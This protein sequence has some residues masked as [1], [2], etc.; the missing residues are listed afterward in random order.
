GGANA[1]L[2]A[3]RVLADGTLDTSF[4]GDG[5]AHA[6]FGPGADEGEDLMIDANG[7][8]V[9]GGTA[10]GDTAMAVARF[11]TDG[12]LDTS[13]D[14]DGKVRIDFAGGTTYENAEAMTL[15]S[16]GKIVIAGRVGNDFAVARLHAETTGS[17]V[18]H[19]AV[20]DGNW[21]VTAVAASSDGTIVERFQYDPY[22][23]ATVL[24]A[25]FAADADGTS[26]IG[27]KHLHQG[28][29]FDGDTGLYHFNVGGNGRDYSSTLG[30]WLEQDR[31]PDGPY[32][33]GMNAYQY[34]G[35]SPVNYLDPEGLQRWY[36]GWGNLA[37]T[38]FGGYGSDAAGQVWTSAS[39]GAHD[40]ALAWANGVVPFGD[41]IPQNW[42]F[43]PCDEML[44]VSETMGQ[45]SREAWLAAAGMKLGKMSAGS[46]G[47]GKEFSH[48]IPNRHGGPRSVWNGNYVSPK[49]HAL[50]DPYRYR[51]MPKTW[52]ANNPMPNVLSQQWVRVPDALKGTA[53]GAMLGAADD[54][55]DDSDPCP[56]D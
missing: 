22:G 14:T 29:R 42:F 28:G 34:V 23:T 10:D 20:Q 31:H 56:C 3:A 45:V 37:Y 48:W 49:T 13:F 41:P 50:S 30:R 19:Y 35:S 36:Q 54:Y 47:K 32:V 9:V 11:N 17:D 7:K 2:V 53:G 15:Q 6:D 40:G 5:L 55:S 1:D 16:D 51:F 18:R 8:I 25:N 4:S 21:N 12:S 52:K 26:D 27:W 44:E 24:D 33:D 43:D 39:E 38:A 46:P